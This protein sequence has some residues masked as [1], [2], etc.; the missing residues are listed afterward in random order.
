MDEVLIILEVL[1]CF[2]LFS[3]AP[4]KGFKSAKGSINAL[5]SEAK[6]TPYWNGLLH[7]DASYTFVG[8]A[9]RA[10]FNAASMVGY[11][12]SAPVYLFSPLDLPLL[13][14]VI[15]EHLFATCVSLLTLGLQPL[16]FTLR[17]IMTLGCGYQ[18][19]SNLDWGVSMEEEQEDWD[20]AINPFTPS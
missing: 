14:L 2:L 12:L 1:M 13:P 17:T 8:H 20:C 16:F 7:L 15:A 10:A 6:V 9:L 19:S 18:E 4:Q 11:I 3:G 5:L